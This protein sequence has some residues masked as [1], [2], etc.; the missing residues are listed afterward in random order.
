M[1][2]LKPRLARR[3]VGWIRVDFGTPGTLA[4]NAYCP[5]RA[6]RISIFQ[7]AEFIGDIQKF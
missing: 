4:P 1:F 6:D 7:E 2:N 5:I 3:N